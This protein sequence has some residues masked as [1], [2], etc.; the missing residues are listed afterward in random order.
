[1]T[2]FACHQNIAYR[3][4]PP[5]KISAAIDISVTADNCIFTRLFFLF[6]GVSEDDMGLFSNAGEKEANQYNW[7]EIVGWSEL[8]KDPNYF[9]ILEMSFLEL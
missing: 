2:S 3:F 5:A 6:R 9:R 7:R 8:S 1:M 4:L